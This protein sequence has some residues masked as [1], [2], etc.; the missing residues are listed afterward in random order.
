M[1][2]YHC[3]APRA[4]SPRAP[5][6][7]THGPC[8]TEGPGLHFTV[9]TLPSP[10][11]QRPIP[12]GHRPPQRRPDTRDTCH[13]RP[14]LRGRPATMGRSGRAG[15]ERLTSY[16]LDATA[17]ENPPS[18]RHHEQ[19]NADLKRE[20]AGP[21]AHGYCPRE[22]VLDRRACCKL[23]PSFVD[24][25]TTP[26]APASSSQLTAERPS[27]TAPPSAMVLFPACRARTFA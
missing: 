19:I 8:E 4:N 2:H 27:G 9:R 6:M 11:G 10:S 12:P 23:G 20:R 18:A 7:A 25:S 22:F 17:A 26:P 21:S 16:R 13:I 3:N 15:T 5:S 24:G 14:A 1:W